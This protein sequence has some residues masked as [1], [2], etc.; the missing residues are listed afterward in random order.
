MHIPIVGNCILGFD[1]LCDLCAEIERIGHKNSETDK[2]DDVEG[3][4]FKQG[5]NISS[6]DID[7]LRMRYKK[8]LWSA[9]RY[10]SASDYRH[11][12]LRGE[13]RSPW[14]KDCSFSLRDQ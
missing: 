6:I 1:T 3:F 7:A 10:L 2:D 9:S 12:F 13:W 8:T 14:V 11:H 5:S 4:V